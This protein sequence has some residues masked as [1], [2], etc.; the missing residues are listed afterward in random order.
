[1]V[2][3]FTH[4]PIWSD[5]FPRPYDT[6]AQYFLRWGALRWFTVTNREI[7][8]WYRVHGNRIRFVYRSIMA[9]PNVTV[10]IARIFRQNGYKHL[11]AA[12]AV[13]PAQT[14]YDSIRPVVDVGRYGHVGDDGMGW[15]RTSCRSAVRFLKSVL[16]YRRSPASRSPVSRE[17]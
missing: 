16:R 9:R 5:V 1:M 6:A 17:I 7:R 11:S 8:Q 13:L 3:H 10:A 12:I 14:T 2:V 4:T 15:R